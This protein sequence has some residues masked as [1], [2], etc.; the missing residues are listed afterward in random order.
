MAVTHWSI[1]VNNDFGTDFAL[2]FGGGIGVQIL[3]IGVPDTVYHNKDPLRVTPKLN[4]QRSTH[5]SKGN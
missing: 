1:A 5:G 3:R 4:G 2:D